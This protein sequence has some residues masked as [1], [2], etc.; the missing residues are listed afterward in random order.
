[1]CEYILTSTQHR[2]STVAANDLLMA[3][4][5]GSLTILVHLDLSVQHQGPKDPPSPT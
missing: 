2:N 5:S 4:N 1:M 3:A